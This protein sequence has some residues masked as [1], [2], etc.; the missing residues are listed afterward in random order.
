MEDEE[1]VFLGILARDQKAG[2]SLKVA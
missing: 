1:V 2:G